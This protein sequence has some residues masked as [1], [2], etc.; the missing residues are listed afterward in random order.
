MTVGEIE[1]VELVEDVRR[2]LELDTANGSITHFTVRGRTTSI[3]SMVGTFRLKSYTALQ[4]VRPTDV[5]YP[6]GER[7]TGQLMYTD[8]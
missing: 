4:G 1:Q 6:L 5:V 2:I 8:P 3:P 7:C